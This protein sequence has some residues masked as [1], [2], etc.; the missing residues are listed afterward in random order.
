MG[1][2][3]FTKQQLQAV[4]WG[5]EGKIV[6][7]EIIDKSRWSTIHRLIFMPEGETKLYEASYSRGA[8]EQQD[9]QP[10]Q[11]VDEDECVEV[12]AFEK[13]VID[14]RPVSDEQT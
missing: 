14:Y 2:R 5:D 3:T 8:T 9:E 10:W 12:E 13:T 1:K 4:L 6:L 11:Y 7:N